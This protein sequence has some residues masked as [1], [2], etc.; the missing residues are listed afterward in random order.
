MVFTARLPKGRYLL[1]SS[2]TGD[3]GFV[4]PKAYAEF[5]VE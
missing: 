2:S 1:L 5:T 4:L 3:D